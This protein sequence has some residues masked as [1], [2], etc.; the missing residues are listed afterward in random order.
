[1]LDKNSIYCLTQSLF[2]ISCW[3]FLFV[4]FSGTA[5]GMPGA[6]YRQRREEDCRKT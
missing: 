2:V 3:K 1:M 5:F 6:L 4:C